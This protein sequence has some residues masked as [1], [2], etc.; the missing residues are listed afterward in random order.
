MQKACGFDL[1]A[2][3]I[4]PPSIVPGRSPFATCVDDQKMHCVVKLLLYPSFVGRP[5]QQRRKN[6]RHF[7][8]IE[9]V[10]KLLC[11]Q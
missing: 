7:H 2:M 6:A 5:I 10:M 4:Q 8:T 11:G 3:L 1:A 9:W